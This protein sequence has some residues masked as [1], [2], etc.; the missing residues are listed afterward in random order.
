[1]LYALLYLSWQG[2]LWLGEGCWKAL[3][4][5]LI[6]PPSAKGIISQQCLISVLQRTRAISE[7]DVFGFPWLVTGR[8]MLSAIIIP[9][10]GSQ[11]CCQTSGSLA[12]AWSERKKEEPPIAGQSEMDEKSH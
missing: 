7:A 10:L 1:M 11:V 3:P 9:C 6:Q 8:C 4:A 2:A 12:I 5:L